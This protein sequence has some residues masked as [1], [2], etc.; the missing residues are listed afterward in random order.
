MI[1]TAIVFCFLAPV[2]PYHIF[3][4]QGK[5]MAQLAQLNNNIKF[6]VFADPCPVAS[7]LL[8]NLNALVPESA[9]LFPIS[10]LS[11]SLSLDEKGLF[12]DGIDLTVLDAVWLQ[13]FPYQNPIIPPAELKQDW[14]LWQFDH[15]IRQQTYSTLFSLIQELD[16][17]GVKVINSMQVQILGFTKFSMLERLRHNG[18]LVPPMICSNHNESVDAF[19]QQHGDVVWRPVS[20]LSAWQRFTD[21]QQANLIGPQY[22][23]IMLAKIIP[24]PLHNSYMLKGRC[25]LSLQHKAPDSTPPLEKLEQFWRVASTKAPN[26]EHLFQTIGGHWLRVNYIISGGDTWVYDVDTDPV[27]TGLPDVFRNHLLN[28]V[29][30]EMTGSVNCL[31]NES[32][33]SL[34]QNRSNMFLSRMY[35]ILF[36]MESSKYS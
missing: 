5:L 27:L 19:C 35:R 4:K 3:Q 13:G 21:K 17:R 12:W 29:A 16:R 36:E 31:Q 30:C 33:L 24:G 23:P 34:I 6:G 10:Q 18:F 8:Q 2:E 25:V 14:S 9:H 15:L 22:P 32:D 26:P 11:L 7:K 28:E 20:G 1:L